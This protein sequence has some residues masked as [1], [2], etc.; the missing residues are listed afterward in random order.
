MLKINNVS[1]SFGGVRAIDNVSFH[2]QDGSITALIGPNGAGKTTMFNIIAGLLEPGQGEIIFEGRNINRLPVYKRARLGISRTF[3]VL[4]HLPELS[5]EDNI[6]LGMRKSHESFWDCFLPQKSRENKL[7]KEADKILRQ[8]DLADK[9][10]LDACELSYGQ[11]KLLEIMRAF[12]Q[13][14]KLILLDEPA[15]GVNPTMLKKISALIKEKQKAGYTL[16]IIEHN[17][18]WVMGL[19]DSVVVFNEGK[20]LTEGSPKEVQKDPRVMRAYLGK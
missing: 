15:S 16:L 12:A 18:P 10:H 13:P 17:I 5:A 19:A 20:K 2:V 9:K 11:K 6:I 14:A 1:K 7:R 3:Q 8:V 4:R